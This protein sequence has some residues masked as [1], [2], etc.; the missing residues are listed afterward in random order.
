MLLSGLTLAV[1]AFFGLRIW[2]DL[3]ASRLRQEREAVTVIAQFHQRLNAH[4]F[5]AICRDADK[6]SDFPN[7]RQD[8]RILLGDVRNRLGSFKSV[9]G[10]EIKVFIEPPS[11]R[12]DIV[13]LFE[14]GE[15][16]EIFVMKEFDERL[17]IVTYRTVTKESRTRAGIARVR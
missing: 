12:G 9:R 16:R 10:S 15:Q 14:K 4:D 8:W 1:P 2:S 11:V 7:L 13:S 3:R 5:D 6:G 17:K